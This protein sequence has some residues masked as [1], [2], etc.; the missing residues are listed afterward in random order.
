MTFLGMSLPGNGGDRDEENIKTVWKDLTD[1]INEKSY[2][3]WTRLG[4]M[5]LPTLPWWIYTFNIIAVKSLIAF[6]EGRNKQGLWKKN[7]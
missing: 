3:A 6:F 2:P 4:F 5:E 1:L 7:S